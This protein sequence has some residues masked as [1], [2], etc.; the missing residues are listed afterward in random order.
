MRNLIGIDPVHKLVA[1]GDMTQPGMQL[2]FCRRDGASAAE[3]MSRMLDSIKSGL[4]ARPR[5]GLYY[6]C[7]GRGPNL[8]GGES[9]E[10]GMIAEALG[11]F[12]LV[13]FLLRWRDFA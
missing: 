1:I 5:G 7:V 13:G 10:V 12:P 2:M 8:F 4:F 3:D 11:D 9:E 6:S